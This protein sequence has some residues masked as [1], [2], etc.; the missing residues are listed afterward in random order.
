MENLEAT[1]EARAAGEL[2]A[3]PEPGTTVRQT[4][5]GWH[6]FFLLLVLVSIGLIGLLAPKFSVLGAWL[7]ILVLLTALTVAVG[8]GVTGLSLGCLIDAHNR[9][10]LARLQAILWTLIVISAFLAGALANISAN[11]ANPGSIADPLSIGVP[12]ELW[13]L[14]GISLTSLIGSPLILSAKKTQQ[15]K[16]AEVERTREILDRQGE[17]VENIDN[18]GRIMIKDYPIKANISDLFKGDEVSNAAQLDLGKVQM[19]YFTLILVFAYG[20]QMGSLFLDS[21]GVVENLPVL[22]TGMLALL[23][24]S[25]AGYLTNKAVPH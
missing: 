24:I 17:D 8:H 14:M 15:P 2:G 9:I 25:H 23:A 19:F 13:I 1:P 3:A 6:T 20:V 7:G 16:D 22:S 18:V 12:E 4:W 21:S 5:R 11:S 10:S